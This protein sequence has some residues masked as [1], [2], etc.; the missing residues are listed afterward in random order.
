MW[1]MVGVARAGGV[2]FWRNGLEGDRRGYDY[3]T[4]LL[5]LGLLRDRRKV[6]HDHCEGLIRSSDPSHLFAFQTP[7]VLLPGVK[8]S[9]LPSV[10]VILTVSTLWR[11]KT[12]SFVFV[13]LTSENSA[14]PPSS[15]LPTTRSLS[16]FLRGYRIL[17]VCKAWI[18]DV[19]GG[20][21]A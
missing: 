8:C 3:W 4:L 13:V 5:L 21:P 2:G 9:A 15:Q 11:G 14:P 17:R 19:Q 16:G 6:Y 18:S 7:F 1:N 12:I 20:T 10:A